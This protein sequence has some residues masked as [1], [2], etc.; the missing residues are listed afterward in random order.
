LTNKS[1]WFSAIGLVAALAVA[2]AVWRFWPRDYS[3]RTCRRNLGIL[4]IAAG[5]VVTGE[6]PEPPPPVRDVGGYPAPPPMADLSKTDVPTPEQVF[7]RLATGFYL[8]PE[9]NR[10]LARCEGREADEVHSSWMMRTASAAELLYP[11]DPSYEERIGYFSLARS[12]TD[13]HDLPPI[14][15]DWNPE[16]GVLARCMWHHLALM[17]DGSIRR[18]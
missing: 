5:R 11:R 10:Y 6:T 15:Y 8:T 4:Y 7:R 1:K 14:S 18:Y 12:W 13:L 9:D 3:E 17:R 16:P 2:L